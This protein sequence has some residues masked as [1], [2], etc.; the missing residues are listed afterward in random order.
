MANVYLNNIYGN[1]A[2]TGFYAGMLAQRNIT[3]ATSTAPVYA[4][5]LAAAQILAA[6]VDATITFDALVT[7]NMA[8]TQLAIT[9]NTIAANEQWRAGLLHSLCFAA[10]FG[11]TWS[12]AS[13]TAAGAALALAIKAAW[14]EGLT[15]LVVP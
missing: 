15:G 9:T 10:V 14:T 5:P 7:T 12:S 1:A 11:S 4:T 8:I 6:A 3:N 2:F 13:A